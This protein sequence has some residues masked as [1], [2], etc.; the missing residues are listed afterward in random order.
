[1]ENDIRSILQ[2]ERDT[3]RYGREPYCMSSSWPRLAISVEGVYS[4]S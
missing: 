3:F 4:L 1:M 2:R